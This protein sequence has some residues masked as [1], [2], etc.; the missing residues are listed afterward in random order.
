[1]RTDFYARLV[2]KCCGHAWAVVA[3]GV[4]AGLLACV[5]VV[6]H[7]QMDSNSENL[8]S[9]QIEFR[10]R[11]AEFDAA[12]PQRTHLTLA[13]IDGVTPERATEAA[14]ALTTALAA[15]K[16]LFPVVRDRAGS[17]FFTHNGL[18]FLTPDEVRDTIQ[19]VVKAQ[20]FLGPLAV[21][22]S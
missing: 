12:F 5:Y 21:D 20:P 18:L 3:A 8:F 19:N 7:F 2:A 10:Q 9:P 17:D 14:K 22:L 16:D 11:Q 4:V 15:R 1:M 13:V 6:Q